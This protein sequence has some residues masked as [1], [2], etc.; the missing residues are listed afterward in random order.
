MIYELRCYECVPGKLP[1]LLRRFEDDALPI[2]AEIGIKATGF[3]TT[4]I[5]D[6]DQSLH[7][8]LAWENL[9]ERESK[10]QTFTTDP[11]WIAARKRT[12]ADGPL[13]ARIRNSILR[14]ALLGFAI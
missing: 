8:M 13:V 14:P 1:S 12:E 3:W 9:A 2:W 10:W 7:Y 11:R 4:V 5:G 6:N